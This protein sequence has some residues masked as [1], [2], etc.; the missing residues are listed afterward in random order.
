M[1]SLPQVLAFEFIDYIKRE[2]QLTENKYIQLRTGLLHKR[3]PACIVL[4]ERIRAI[5]SKDT[6]DQF[7]SNLNFILFTG[8]LICYD[9]L[10][11]GSVLTT[12]ASTPSPDLGLFFFT[13]SIS[14]L[15]LLNSFTSHV[16]PLIFKTRLYSAKYETYFFIKYSLI[17]RKPLRIGAAVNTRPYNYHNAANP[18]HFI[19]FAPKT[20][21]GINHVF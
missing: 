11:A 14:L 9:L 5:L 10:P 20:G 4:D 8:Q 6:L 16:G 15:K 17:Y 12:K 1:L 18:S 2:Q 19:F 7:F 21:S 13:I 3:K